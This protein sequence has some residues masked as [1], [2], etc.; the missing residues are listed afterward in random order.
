MTTSSQNGMSDRALAGRE[1]YG[2]IFQTDATDAERTMTAYAGEAFTQQSFEIAGGPGWTSPA[3]TDRDRSMAILGA[4]AAQNVTG[5][6]QANYV[7]MARRNGVSQEGLEALMMLLQQ[8]V[9]QPYATLAMEE[10]RRPDEQ[11]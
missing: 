2:R 10:I 8:Y 11:P 3:L 9:G 5:R 7:S 4:L 6:V 1:V